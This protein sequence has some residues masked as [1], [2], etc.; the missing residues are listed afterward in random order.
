MNGETHRTQPTDPGT[1][2]RA[3]AIAERGH[4]WLAPD[5]DPP[6]APPEPFTSYLTEHTYAGEPSSES[7]DGADLGMGT[8]GIG[9]GACD[10]PTHA[11]ASLR[12]EVKEANRRSSGGML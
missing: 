11:R 6:T 2:Q 8:V 12:D 9:I 1:A 4:R 10:C 3:A 5:E 7:A